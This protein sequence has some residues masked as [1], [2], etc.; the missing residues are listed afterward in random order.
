MDGS[1]APLSQTQGAAADASERA[2][3]RWLDALQRIGRHYRLPSSPQGAMQ[4]WHAHGDV[5]E[6]DRIEVLA[7]AFGLTARHVDPAAI[8]VSDWHLPFVLQLDDGAIALVHSLAADG[9]AGA[10]LCADHALEG[11]FALDTLLAR[12]R[13]LVLFRPARAVPDARVDAYIKP[14]RKNWLR[15]IILRDPAS[16]GHVLIASLIANALG[17]AGILFSMQVYDRVVPAQSFNT[18]YV[19]FSGVLL[20]IGFDFLMRRARLGITDILGKQADLQMSDVVFGRAL[21]VR[22]RARPTSTGAFIAQLRDVDQVREMLTSTTVTALAD[23][24]F[25]FL[26]AVIYWWLVG[27]LVLIPIGALIVLVLP[28]LL[29]QR[30]LRA[31]ANEAMREASLRNAMLVEA[32]Q[33]IEDIKSLQAEGR[34]QRQWNQL[35]AVTGEAQLRLRSITNGLNIWTQNV[36]TG[37]YAMTVFIGAPMVIAGDL[38][39]GAL[40]GAS[41]LGSRMLA[42]MGQLSQLAGRWQQARIAKAGLDQLMQMP[43][44]HP[45]AETRIHRPRIEGRYRL[46]R[47]VFRYGDEAAPTVLTVKDMA[48]GKGER[49]AV[50]GRNGAGKSTLLLALSGLLDPSDGEILLDDLALHHIDPADVRRDVALVTQNARLFFGTLRDNITMGA[51][52]ADDAA[53]AKVLAMLGA[54]TFVRRLGKGLDHVV[55]EGGHG[56]SGGQK[57]LILL[58]RQLIRDPSIVLLDE[59]TAAMDEAT[60]RHFIKEF[61]AWSAGRTVVIATHRMRVLELVDRLIVVENGQVALDDTKE[62]GL[63]KLVGMSKVVGPE[64]VAEGLRR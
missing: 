6:Q 48:I 47:A 1:G 2:C 49:I 62:K 45:E 40:V 34:F 35:N 50:L 12:T 21:R 17:L 43:V 24:P 53:I 37:V 28:G 23:L 30:R 39:T 7:Q 8:T 3:A 41:I 57:Q 61:D 10:W 38:T 15:R 4:A 11:R 14:F 36:Q 52:T 44:D 16:Y 51:P 13:R 29:L 32:V 20:A 58:A 26:F 56:L 54:Q 5:P 63:R 27:P 46:K 25:F 33:G 42:P 64:A 19:L 18:L 31:H 59:P 22:N 55:Q 60:E 9:E